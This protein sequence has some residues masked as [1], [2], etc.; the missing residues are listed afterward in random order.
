[1]SNSEFSEKI[2][3]LLDRSF[4]I[5]TGE[6]PCAEEYILPWGL[7]IGIVLLIMIFMMLR[8]N[9]KKKGGKGHGQEKDRNET[10]RS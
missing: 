4:G 10:E 6:A 1:M 2:L 7:V 5:K 9:L 3:E 8:R